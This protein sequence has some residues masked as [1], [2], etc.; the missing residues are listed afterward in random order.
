MSDAAAAPQGLNS[1]SVEQ[2]PRVSEQGARKRK[3][4][5]LRRKQRKQRMQTVGEGAPQASSA[6]PDNRSQ[7]A[8]TEPGGA[9]GGKA[10]HT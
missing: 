3:S 9:A 10:A 4:G 8:S 2:Q 7:D 1:G 5:A 6:S